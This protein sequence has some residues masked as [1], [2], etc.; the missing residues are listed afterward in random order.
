MAVRRHTKTSTIQSIRLKFRS[1]IR[2]HS[3]PHFFR[4]MTKIILGIFWLTFAATGVAA[5]DHSQKMSWIEF[6]NHFITEI[7]S[8]KPKRM[9]AVLQ[10]LGSFTVANQDSKII[11]KRTQWATDL[12]SGI[13][14]KNFR[15]SKGGKTY[16]K[17]GDKFLNPALMVEIKIGDEKPLVKFFVQKL[18][19]RLFS[20]E[21]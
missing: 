20:L 11:K 9:K 3:C 14:T 10:E 5:S 6:K 16:L 19:T 15:C 12:I 13:Q 2:G 7:C 4:Q 1:F 17:R 8:S 21:Y 18:N